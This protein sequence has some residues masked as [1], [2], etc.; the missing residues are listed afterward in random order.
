M[1]TVFISEAGETLTSRQGMADFALE[2]RP[3][4]RSLSHDISGELHE[5]NETLWLLYLSVYPSIRLSVRPSLYFSS[6]TEILLAL[7][8]LF[9]CQVASDSLPP[10]GPQHSRLPRPL[11]SPGV[12]LNRALYKFQRYSVL[13]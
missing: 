7:F 5:W 11:L 1:S 8:L 10:H 6:F 12:C 2:D 13:I 4:Q 3:D 9:S